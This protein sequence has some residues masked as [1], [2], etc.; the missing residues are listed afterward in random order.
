M[1]RRKGLGSLKSFLWF[2]PQLSR[3]SSLFFSILNL[4]KVYSWEW[5]QWLTLWWPHHPLFTDVTGAILLKFGHSAYLSICCSHRWLRPKSPVH[6]LP[7][8]TLR[9]FWEILTGVSYKSLGVYSILKIA[10]K[11]NRI[12]IHFL[13]GHRMLKN[14]QSVSDF[15]D[16]NYEV[17]WSK[18]TCSRA[19]KFIISGRGRAE[20]W[21]PEY[22]SNILF[23]L[24]LLPSPRITGRI[25]QAKADVNNWKSKQT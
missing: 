12:R 5:L 3:A 4:L 18:V 11:N 1:R 25:T 8:I 16:L 24:Y 2:A 19:Q 6:C 7:G 13:E 9:N 21:F 14:S 23:Q 22:W 15:T 17:Q 20:F 10:F